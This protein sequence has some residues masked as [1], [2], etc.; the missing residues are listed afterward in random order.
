M[1]RTVIAVWPSGSDE[2]L[3]A[4]HFE[5]Q[6][7][8][9]PGLAD[10]PG[11][12]DY[13]ALAYESADIELLAQ[14]RIPPK[15]VRK[16]GAMLYKALLSDK[17]VKGALK[18]AA[19]TD[20]GTTTPIYIMYHQS[21]PEWIPWETLCTGRGTFLALEER[22]PVA[23]VPTKEERSG[24]TIDR[25]FS[26]P[27]KILAV[28]SAA[29]VPA[30]GEWTALY[31][32]VRDMTYPVSMHVLISEPDL[33]AHIL[34]MPAHPNV[35][36]VAHATPGDGPD[37]GVDPAPGQSP[38]NV[39]IDV[40]YVEPSA[41]GLIETIRAF[42]PHLLHF[43]CHG[44]S[45]PSPELQIATRA[46]WKLKGT[47]R[48][49][50]ILR[51]TPPQFDKLPAT[52]SD[53]SIVALNCCESSA[54]T[55]SIESIAMSLVSSGPG[56]PA[57]IGMREPI[58]S[59]AANLFTREFYGSILGRIGRFLEGQEDL[60]DIDW[61]AAMSVPRAR[62]AEARGAG[63]RLHASAA[64]VKVWTLPVI[65][66]RPEP[67]RHHLAPGKSE[68]EQLQAITPLGAFSELYGLQQAIPGAPE[69]FV[70]AISTEISALQSKL[71]GR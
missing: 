21:G 20:A 44:T 3:P 66:V 27:A 24:A 55:G 43:F 56:F 53:L 17:Y 62:L 54:S 59:A 13:S 4:K 28:L 48:R 57:V 19:D 61:I 71:P 31:E 51:L 63:G 16:V 2:A 7:A 9:A 15:H 6:L 14:P 30:T 70:D 41:T 39:L 50:N 52:A 67:F 45:R 40:A 46:W 34:Q 65:Y 29:D 38:P 37:G 49:R 42:N 33:M 36:I 22:M 68:A 35:R 64:N 47:G 8:S 69:H 1:D 25:V 5:F 10:L 11:R 18:A 12:G 26:L 58:D 23:R 32:T 60:A